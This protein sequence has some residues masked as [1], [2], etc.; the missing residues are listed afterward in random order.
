[1]CWC[2]DTVGLNGRHQ[3]GSTALR[4]TERITLADGGKTLYD[5]ITQEDPDVYAK[6]YTVKYKYNRLP[7]GSGLMEYV[8]EVDPQGIHQVRGQEPLD[9]TAPPRRRGGAIR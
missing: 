5:E 7:E 1:M 2:I 4:I 8:C 3:K 9:R 6:P